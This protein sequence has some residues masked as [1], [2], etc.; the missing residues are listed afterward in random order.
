MSSAECRV[1]RGGTRGSST[2]GRRKVNRN[3]S[4]LS[5]LLSAPCIFTRHSFPLPLAPFCLS[6]LDSRHSSLPHRSNRTRQNSDNL[7]QQFDSFL[8][9]LVRQPVLHSFVAP[10]R[11]TSRTSRDVEKTNVLYSAESSITLF[12]VR[13]DRIRA[14]HLLGN[15]S[16]TPVISFEAF[17]SATTRSKSTRAFSYAPN[18]SRPRW[19]IVDIFLNLPLDPRPSTLSSLAPRPSSLPPVHRH[20]EEKR[21]T[22]SRIVLGPDLTVVRFHDGAR[23]G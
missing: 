20:R 9:N 13:T 23:D 11:L 14:A 15:Q 21:R 4:S 18:C 8:N 1:S 3:T 6:S 10:T 22:H 7:V 2:E 17:I 5:S 12:D 16:E 19:L